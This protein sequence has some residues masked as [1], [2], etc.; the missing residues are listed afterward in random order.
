MRKKGFTF[1][2]A[3]MSFIITIFVGVIITLAMV[4][5]T[6]FH[7]YITKKFIIERVLESTQAQDMLLSLLEAEQEGVKF[8]QAIVYA[9]YQDSEKPKIWNGEKIVEYNLEEIAKNFLSYFYE[10]DN[11]WLFIYDEKKNEIKTIC[12]S[13]EN[14]EDL[15]KKESKKNRRASFPIDENRWLVLYINLKTQE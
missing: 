5:M 10:N 9:L 2:L 3:V 15:F 1:S 8:R 14:I 13:Q 6:T 11:Y 12:K 4:F 7:I